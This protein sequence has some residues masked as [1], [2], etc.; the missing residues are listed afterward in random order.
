MCTYMTGQKEI[1][2]TASSS[3]ELYSRLAEPG[4]VFTPEMFC[5]WQKSQ[6]KLSMSLRKKEL[7][8]KFKKFYF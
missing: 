8:I 4:I 5:G 3:Q 2:A 7:R 1:G 6:F